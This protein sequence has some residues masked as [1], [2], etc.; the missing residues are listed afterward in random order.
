MDFG[1]TL[2]ENR[3]AGPDLEKIHKRAEGLLNHKVKPVTLGKGKH[4]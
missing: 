4:L 3:V 2:G 1:F